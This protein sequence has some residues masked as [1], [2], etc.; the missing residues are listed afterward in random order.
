MAN[1]VALVSTTTSNAIVLNTSNNISDRQRRRMDIITR[2]VGCIP[3]RLYHSKYVQA[4]CNH[5]LKG[6]RISHD[7][8]VPECTWHH[9]GE[10]LTGVTR[11]QMRK[12]FGPSRK[13]NRKRFA[14]YFG[15]DERLLKITNLYVKQFEDDTIG[16]PGSVL[17]TE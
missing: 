1:R 10:M 13:L 14:A 8:T 15:S 7:A 5:L 16:G 12:A 2:E 3:C 17:I 4:E 6:Y 9:R 11:R